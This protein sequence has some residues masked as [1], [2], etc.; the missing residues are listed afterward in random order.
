MRRL[1]YLMILIFVF[2]GCATR[3]EKFSNGKVYLEYD[4]IF[5]KDKGSFYVPLEWIGKQEEEEVEE[6]SE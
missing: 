3:S 4:I 6:R 2:C 5:N 1:I